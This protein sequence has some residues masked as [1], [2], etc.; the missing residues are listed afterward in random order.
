MVANG[1]IVNDL[2]STT[3]DC[4]TGKTAEF[5]GK[6]VGDLL[7]HKHITW[8]WFEEGFKPMTKNGRAYSKGQAFLRQAA[9]WTHTFQHSSTEFGTTY[10]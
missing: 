4:S 3:D 2:D 8:D 10:L 1:T 6:N 7:N 9:P 5:S